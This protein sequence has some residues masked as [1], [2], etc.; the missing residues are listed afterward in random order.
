[1]RSA[2]A[3]L[4]LGALL[5]GGAA[6][7]ALAQGPAAPLQQTFDELLREA[8]EG[9]DRL[10]AR[11]PGRGDLESVRRQLERVQEWTRGGRRLSTAQLRW[12]SFG[13]IAAREI[14][15]LDLPLAEELH[16][17]LFALRNLPG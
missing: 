13:A 3:A 7:R 11:H 15:P 14:E 5:A 4:A 10:V 6:P 12:L 16:E 17:L 2:L 1:M 9:M 8:R